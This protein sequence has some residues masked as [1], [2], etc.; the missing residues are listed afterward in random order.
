[1]IVK[2]VSVET[3]GGAIAQ[4]EAHVGRAKRTI[5]FVG[6]PRMLAE[7]GAEI[8]RTGKP[9]EAEIETWQILG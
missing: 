7:I 3:N 6:E 9:V 1:M 8:A 5:D 4:A 2:V